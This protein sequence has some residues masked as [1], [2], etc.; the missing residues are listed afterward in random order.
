MDLAQK[1][2]FDLG[3]I[4]F[5]AWGTV[6]VALSAIAFGRDLFPSTQQTDRNPEQRTS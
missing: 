4:F 1:L 6:L 3:W 5:A 2:I